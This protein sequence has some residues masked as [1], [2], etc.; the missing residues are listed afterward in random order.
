M[1]DSIRMLIRKIESGNMK[2]IRAAAMIVLKESKTQKD[3]TFCE[4]MIKKLENNRDFIQL[5]YSVNGLLIAED[6]S[7]YPEERYLW[8][9]QEEEICRS[10]M[11]LYKVA[12]KLQDKGIRYTP[13]AI[14]WGESGCGKTELAKYIAYRMELPYIYVR[15]SSLVDSH[16]GETQKNLS[17]IFD[18]IKKEPCVCCFDEIDA[19]GI[20]RGKVQDLG[21]M[22]RILI[23]LMQEMD[24]LPNHT[25]VIG[26]T[27]R[28]DML[29]RALIRRF[30]YN[31]EIKPFEE[32]EVRLAVQKFLR[33]AGID[34][35]TI[36]E[37]VKTLNGPYPT[38][39]FKVIQRC[40]E[41]IVVT[42]LKDMGSEQ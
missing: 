22:S 41:F 5:P 18:F 38:P 19:I 6:V 29:D 7:Q 14:F 34:N 2:E 20:E 16:L 39:I 32:L 26:T 15:F 37:Y 3:A 8:R 12:N 21:E 30:S 42:M 4:A 28:F 11:N 33:Y 31:A 17:K 40:T 9:I 35:E 10:I 13:T 36:K 1:N 23:S 25:I 27:N 24:T